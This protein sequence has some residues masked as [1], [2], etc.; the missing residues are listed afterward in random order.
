VPIPDGYE[1]TTSQLREDQQARHTV[2]MAARA[3]ARGYLPTVVFQRTPA[4]ARDQDAASCREAGEGVARGG[5][6]RDPP[7]TLRRA[8]L[9]TSPVGV[10]CQMDILAPQGVALIT[11]L[12]L[13]E[14]T[15]LM[16]CNYAD[17]DAAAEAVCKTTLGALRTK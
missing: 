8:T 5:P 7:W 2:A 15:W 3:P 1:D 12:D 4:M 10:A 17:G 13:P 9:V 16:T 14:E 11:E 6:D